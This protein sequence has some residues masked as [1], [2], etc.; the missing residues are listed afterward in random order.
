MQGRRRTRGA[1]RAGRIAGSLTVAALA[2]VVTGMD[3]HATGMDGE[4]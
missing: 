2:T 3:A 4:D 1:R